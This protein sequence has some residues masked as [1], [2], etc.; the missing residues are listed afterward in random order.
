MDPNKLKATDTLT[1]SLKLIVTISTIYFGGILAY[2]SN[3]STPG[4]LWSYY[5]ALSFLAISAILSVANIN[6]LINKLYRGEEDLIKDKEVKRLNIFASFSLL[7]GVISGAWFLSEQ[8]QEPPELNTSSSTV[9]TDSS[10]AVGKDNTSVIKIK[11][12]SSGKIIE[13]EIKPN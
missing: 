10:I 8:T 7:L 12:D 3:L 2:R 9:I 13:V 11:K 1:E 4:A 6:S 5:S